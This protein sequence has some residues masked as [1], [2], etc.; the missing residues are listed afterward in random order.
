MTSTFSKDALRMHPGTHHHGSEHSGRL[1]E[2]IWEGP[3]EEAG[4][5]WGNVDS[6]SGSLIPTVFVLVV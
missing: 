5:V 4:N 6:S 2:Y 1:L 3:L